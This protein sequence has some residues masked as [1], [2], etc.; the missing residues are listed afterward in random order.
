MTHARRL[1]CVTVCF[2]TL[3]GILIPKANA[4]NF[5]VTVFTDTASGGLAGTGAGAAGDLRAQ[6]L[7]ANAAPGADTIS[8]VCGGPSCTITLGGP[9]PAI[10]ESLTIDGGTLGNIVIDG[11]QRISRLLR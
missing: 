6:I 8:F 10:T 5:P 4:A 1:L 7:A 9:L 3:F 11:G 2:F